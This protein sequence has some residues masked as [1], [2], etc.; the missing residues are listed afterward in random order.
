MGT[1][2]NGC[3]II[4]ELDSENVDWQKKVSYYQFESVTEHFYD[5]NGVQKFYKRVARKDYKSVT[6][7]R[8]YELLMDCSKAYLLHRYHTIVDKVK[9]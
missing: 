6:L 2:K 4:N 7:K 3:T 1:C 9:D 8:V 5:K